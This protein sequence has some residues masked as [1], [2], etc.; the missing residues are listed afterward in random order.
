M[1]PDNQPLEKEIP[2]VNFWG[3]CKKNSFVAEDAGRNKATP[4]KTGIISA[5]IG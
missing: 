4:P 1:E 3:V 2:L 5:Y